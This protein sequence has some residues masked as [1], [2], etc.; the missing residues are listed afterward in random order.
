MF[1]CFDA[2]LHLLG[3]TDCITEHSV[4][5]GRVKRAG[6]AAFLARQQQKYERLLPAAD[7]RLQECLSSMIK[8]QPHQRVAFILRLRE[9]LQ[10]HARG[11]L[12]MLLCSFSHSCWC[13]NLSAKV[14]LVCPTDRLRGVMPVQLTCRAALLTRTS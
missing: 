12:P 11:E 4:E 10:A 5:V 14:R 7:A 6:Q 3:S 9:A 1:L 2:A 8:H 13:D